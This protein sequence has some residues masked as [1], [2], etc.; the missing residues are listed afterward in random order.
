MSWLLEA[1]QGGRRLL[2]STAAVS[3][4]LTVIE[5]GVDGPALERAEQ[6]EDSAELAPRA[7]S[8]V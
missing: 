4:A 2:L 6:E 7:T 1:T 8:T 5:A 3:T